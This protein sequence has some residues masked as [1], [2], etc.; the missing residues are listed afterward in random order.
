M[1][2]KTNRI[3]LENKEEPYTMWLKKE[4]SGGVSNARW[5]DYF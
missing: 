2:R 3:E 1:L 4:T 5:M